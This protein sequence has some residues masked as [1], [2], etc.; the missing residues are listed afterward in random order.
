MSR[1]VIFVTCHNIFAKTRTG[2]EQCSLRNYEI[3]CSI[4]GENNIHV[5]IIS[6]SSDFHHAATYFR[7]ASGYFELLISAICNTN[8][9]LP[10]EEK[11]IITFIQQHPHD[12][13]FFDSSLFG[14]I[15]LRFKNEKQILFLHN[16]E[17]SYALNKVKEKG[18]RYL[19]QMF[20]FKANEKMAVKYARKII[21][22]NSRDD[23]M[24]IR[25]YGRQS[26]MLLPI[27]FHDSFNTTICEDMYKNGNIEKK[28]LLFLGSLFMPNL[29]GIKWFI[30]EVMSQL[31]DFRLTI[32][33]K[34]FEKE[35]A[36]FQQKNV[37]VV[38]TVDSSAFYYYRHPIVVMPIFIG[39]GM[40]VKT[41][42]AMMYGRIILATDEALEGYNCYDVEGIFRCNTA[43][44]YIQTLTQITRET[45]PPFQKH[46][47]E[48]F[49]NNYETN[50]QYSKMRRLIND[51]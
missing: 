28:N 30:N 49:L 17:Y 37:D 12:F 40:K 4:C 26:D 45:L 33:G 22:L 35:R 7:G 16:I 24:L 14:R 31:T 47:R 34:G 8:L 21:A 41:A 51:L 42:E 19:P 23:N 2:G 44:E 50:N 10:T 25:K 13:I 20:T 9:Y 1:N 3:L 46:V 6:N 5:C 32:V 11:K 48:L 39:S 38:G 36:N 43:S 15:A 29:E 18:I 27:S